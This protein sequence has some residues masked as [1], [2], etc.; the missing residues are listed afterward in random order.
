ML[1]RRRRINQNER[2]YAARSPTWGER[3]MP[4]PDSSGDGT[5]AAP[6]S[7]SLP[8]Y[9]ASDA[10]PRRIGKFEIRQLLGEGAFGRVFLGFDAE[11][12]RLV[13]I[14]VPKPEGFT[15]D[16]RERFLR[17]ARATAKI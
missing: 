14:K 3:P 12:D 15:P 13:A 8:T 9:A 6:P 4:E 5:R 11:L 16:M 10:A 17:E 7:G 2:E 1:G